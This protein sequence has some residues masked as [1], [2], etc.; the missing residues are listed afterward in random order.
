MKTR[1]FI[2]NGAAA[3]LLL[4]LVAGFTSCATSNMTREEKAAMELRMA[5]AVEDSLAH[6]TF[7]VDVNFVTPQRMPSRSLTYGYGVKV[8]GDT[9]D[10]YLPFFGRVYRAD[11]GDQTGL[12][13]VDRIVSYQ[14]VKVKK[15]RYEVELI[16]RRRL[17]TLIYR[18]DIFSNGRVSLMVRSDNRD[19][20]SFSGELLVRE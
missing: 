16:V 11:F 3:I 18:F 14:G 10:S 5:Q 2:W 8:K 19:T 6:R 4:M 7:T 9:I 13:Y 12:N 1:G 15:D 17:E 20:M